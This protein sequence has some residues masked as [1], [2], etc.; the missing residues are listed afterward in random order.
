MG[1]QCQ[2]E[3]GIPDDG[4]P[5][6]ALGEF[7][8]FAT[9]F[10]KTVKRSKGKIEASDHRHEKPG[11]LPDHCQTAGL[12][13]AKKYQTGRYQDTPG[14]YSHSQITLHCKSKQGCKPC[15]RFRI[16]FKR[17]GGGPFQMRFFMA[18]ALHDYV[19]Q[20]QFKKYLQTQNA[21]EGK[22]IT[23]FLTGKVACDQVNADRPG[24]SREPAIDQGVKNGPVNAHPAEN[25][26]GESDHG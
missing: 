17:P 18:G 2:P 6:A 21:G 26:F 16:A 8:D 12:T 20:S 4:H 11:P 24:E 23:L 19:A 7:S 15:F 22:K 25:F 9:P 1:E 14:N 10:Q 5:S 13:F 3:T